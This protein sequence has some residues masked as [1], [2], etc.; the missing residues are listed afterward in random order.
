MATPE[1]PATK[2]RIEDGDEILDTVG[3]IDDG[4][5][6]SIV[7]PHLAEKAVLNGIGKMAK[8]KPLSL[9][10]ALKEADDAQSFTFSGTGTPPR[11]VL[12]LSTGPLALNNV[13]FLVADVDLA[14]EDIL[15][16]L[17]VLRHL[18]VD[19]K[20][21]LERDR[22]RLDETVCS[23]VVSPPATG[24]T[25]CRLMIARHNRVVD[26]AAT[27]RL[28]RREGRRRFVPGP[29]SPRSG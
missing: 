17:P 24:G 21:M 20:T 10:V 27:R 9:Q 4:S 5:D 29:V 6:E 12:R 11:I 28:L 18:G 3:R 13:K 7:S 8:I 2:I 14:A 22:K 19:T 25:V 1:T 16:G 23:V 15:I 26:K